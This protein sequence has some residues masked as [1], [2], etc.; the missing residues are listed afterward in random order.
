V[1]LF[2]GQK[3]FCNFGSW[4]N[5]TGIIAVIVA[6][7]VGIDFIKD[8]RTNL[9]HNLRGHINTDTGWWYPGYIFEDKEYF[10]IIKENKQLE[11][12]F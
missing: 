3:V 6:D 10:T 1:K 2:I 5:H 8:P 11:F 7:E 9:G 12:D 4:K